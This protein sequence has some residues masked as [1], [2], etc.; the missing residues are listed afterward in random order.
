MKVLVLSNLYPPDTVGGYELGCRQVV[1][2]LR[3]RGHD[4]R[5]LTTAPR[6]PVETPPH[7]LRTLKLTDM[8]DYYSDAHSTPVALRLKE[9]EAFQVNAYNVHAL[10]ATLREFE[11][12]VVYLWMLVGVGGLGLIGCLQH[13]RVPWVWHLMDD[14][15]AKL[16]TIFYRVEPALAREY[17]RQ[18]RGTYLAC[19]RQLVDQAARSGVVLGD[20]VELV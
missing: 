5:V 2:A 18:V 14:V 1:D 7:V 4:V 9:S 12:D 10:L 15:P 6:T 19:S 13:L 16:C 11:P 3:G 8:W 17:S 20:R